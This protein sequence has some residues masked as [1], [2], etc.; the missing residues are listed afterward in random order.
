MQ[1]G[2]IFGAPGLPKTPQELARMRAVAQAL[3]RPGPAPHNIGEGLTAI[4]NALAYR[5]MMDRIGQAQTAGNTS[6]ASAMSG[7][8]S[9]LSGS[10]A[11]AP[12][13]PSVPPAAFSPS[14][15]ADTPS[16]NVQA[17]KPAAPSA[18]A[19]PPEAFSPDLTH[20]G[21]LSGG[22]VSQASPSLT[23]AIAHLESSNSP[24]NGPAGRY[25]N[26]RYQQF[27]A[28]VKQYG[29][30][31][32]GVMNYAKQ[33]L[34]ANPNATFGDMY[35]GYVTGTGDPATA[36]MANLQ[37]TT[38]PGAQG[39]YANLVHNSPIDPNTPLAQL[40]GLRLARSN[41]LAFNG[42]PQAMPIPNV[43]HAP[44]AVPISEWDWQCCADDGRR[45]I[46]AVHASG[47]FAYRSD[48]APASYA[49]AAPPSGLQPFTPPANLQM[50][51]TRPGAPTPAQ[52]APAAPQ[53]ARAASFNS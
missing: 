14:P 2:F 30:G 41:A 38:Q 21:D 5:G 24:V 1:A 36:R 53:G 48:D 29:A 52:A 16:V 19:V 32:S 23:D 11:A 42:Q 4:G 17:P 31:D 15:M 3:A 7:I 39:A 51:Q 28:F 43:T 50:V 18:P 34:A 35:G 6:A 27:P 44:Q 33:V 20:A 49:S 12:A 22:N 46:A 40:L 45:Y 26:Y 37:T 9:G 25:A 10:P 13:V 8:L 47:Q